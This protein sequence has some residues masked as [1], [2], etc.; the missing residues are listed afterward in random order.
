MSQ[1]STTS[2]MTTPATPGVS[3][4]TPTTP[5]LPPTAPKRPGAPRT[6]HGESFADPWEWLRDKEDPTVLAHLEAEN[7]WS[8]RITA[9]TRPL[10]ERLVSEFRAHTEETDTSVPVREGDWW[11]FSRTTEGHS[12]ASH[13]RVPVD[14]AT[15]DPVAPT[16]RPGVPLPGEELLV[17]EEAQ[18]RGQ[19]FFRLTALS[20]SPDAT[21]IAWQRDLLGD[22]RWT[23]I[24]QD[25]ASGEVVDEG[26]TGTGQG[27]AWSADGRF[28]LYPRVDEAWRQHQVWLHEIGTDPASD[29][30]VLEEPD[31]RFALYFAP[32]RDR[33]WVEVIAESTTTSEVW[34]WP[35]THPTCAPLPVTGRTRDVL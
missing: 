5:G 31:E 10:A 2:S 28:L 27:L 24:V 19:E 8:D 21:R 4:S 13:H 25:V 16:V 17:D 33:A 1:H 7:A 18:A 6:F 32:C 15:P 30:L 23:V 12:Y 34:L 20:P 9:P 11:Y 14:T 35:T 22:E 3:P 26:V 29:R